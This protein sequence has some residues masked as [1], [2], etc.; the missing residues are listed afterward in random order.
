MI[1]SIPILLL[2]RPYVP[3]YSFTLLSQ[4]DMV[5]NWLTRLCYG[6]APSALARSA[7]PKSRALNS[8][9]PLR[10]LLDG[11]QHQPMR[12]QIK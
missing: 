5:K 9:E 1:P 10:S 7:G 4:R 2:H 8:S 12:E 3:R 11:T 6:M